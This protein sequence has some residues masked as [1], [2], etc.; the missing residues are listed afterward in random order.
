MARQPLPSK[1]G[2]H[3]RL[4]AIGVTFDMTMLVHDAPPEERPTGSPTKPSFLERN[5]RRL[6]E[7]GLVLGIAGIVIGL[8]LAAIGLASGALTTS[9]D[10]NQAPQ[11][12]GAAAVAAA[13]TIDQAR[14]V[15]FERY[16]RP[17]P[18]LPAVP[19]GKVKR[20]KIEVYEH[21]TQVAPDLAPTQVWSYAVNGVEHRGTGVSEPLVVN[22]GDRVQI[23]LVNGSSERMHVRM[24]HS[25]DFHSSEL[26]P[27]EAFA[28]IAPGGSHRFSFVAKH[29]GV[30]MYHC[31]TNPVLLHTGA[32]MV[33]A[34]IVKPKNLA[35]VDKELWLTQQEFYIG[36]PGGVADMAK[37][38]AKR[39]DVIAFNG[40]ANQYKDQPIVVGRGEKVR[41]YVLNAGPSI[42][43]AFHVIGTV[44]DRTVIEGAVGHDAQ[45]VNLAPSQGG[46]VEFTLDQEG[47]YP[48]VTHAFGDMVRGAAGAFAT[49]NAAPDH[50]AH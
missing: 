10:G 8:V 45:T 32:G 16:Q 40:Y 36:K 30:F 19:P 18:T 5:H 12:P 15:K 48:F 50:S 41:L 2:T 21:V 46:W 27:A 4:R 25:I 29:P 17:D 34:M 38:E 9:D 47:T 7:L 42:W 11:A 3:N 49:K 24:P 26:N 28:T 31:A 43:S 1:L 23:D 44:F 14:G 37:M 22:E 20:F 33:G 39:P 35:P 6:Q 13:P